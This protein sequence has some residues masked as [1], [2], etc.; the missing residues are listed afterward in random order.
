MGTFCLIGVGSSA[1][2]YRNWTATTSVW[3][4]GDIHSYEAHRDGYCTWQFSSC[5]NEV[6]KS[7]SHL[8]SPAPGRTAQF[9][10]LWLT[11]SLRPEI[12]IVCSFL[13]CSMFAFALRGTEVLVW[14]RRFAV[15]HAESCRTIRFDT[16]PTNKKSRNPWLV[17]PKR[18]QNLTK[19][20]TRC[21]QNRSARAVGISKFRWAYINGLNA[22]KLS[23]L[24]F[25]SVETRILL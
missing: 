6:G 13:D 9:S 7:A 24:N 4:R 20:V 2:L 22:H 11:I 19:A 21:S 8:V 15:L 14:N 16:E 10:Y 17:L 5:P 25:V 18:L 12:M 23:R 3:T 1:I